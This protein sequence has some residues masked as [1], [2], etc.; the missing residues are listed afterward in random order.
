VDG[1]ASAEL[2]TEAD[3][4]AEI[5]ESAAAVAEGSF[6]PDDLVE[7]L[8]G[9]KR[10]L[11]RDGDVYQFLI[12]LDE[13]AIYVGDQPRRYE[14]VVSTIEALIEG[15]NP[16]ILGTG[17]WAMRD[18][19]QRF[20]GEIDDEA[21]YA[22]EVK[23]EGADTETIVRKRWLQKSD[24][25]T[26]Y[27][28]TELLEEAPEI[29][30]TRTDDAPSVGLE[31]PAEAYPF[32][33]QDLRL[34]RA[35]MQGL[36][37]GDRETDRE[38][39]QGRALLV[40]VRSLFADYGWADREPGVV[41]SWDVLYDVIKTDTVLIP[42]W[43][44]DLIERVGNSIDD[45]L[46]TRT[47]KAL[48][49][50][51]QVDTVPRTPANLA[52]LLADHVDVDLDQLTADVTDQLEA[53]ASKNLIREDVDES[54]TTYT[55]LS[56]ED[57]RFWQEV[58]EE[59]SDIPPHQLRENI[60]QFLENADQSRLTG[61][62]ATS[63]GTF[64]E[65][66]DV[67]YSIRYSVDRSIPESVTG[68]HDTIVIRLL[69][70]DREI[71]REERNQWQE[72]NGGPNGAEDVLVSV[73]LTEAVRRQVR[74]LI[75]MR[76]V[77]SGMADPRPEYRIR[78]GTLEEEIEDTVKD[79][80]NDG[81]VYVP[82]RETAY[83]S[84]LESFDEAV[85]EAVAEKFPNR[86]TIERPIQL[87][88]LDSLIDFFDGNGEWPLTNADADLL[89]VNTVPRTITDGWV[90][91]F[92][93]TFE[94]ED[95]VSGEQILET[96]EGRRG[97]FLGTPPEALHSLLFVLVADNRIEVRTDGER[98]TDP[99]D[100]ARIITR[101]TRFGDAVVGFD[102]DPPAEDLDDVYEAL[103]GETPG[104]DDTSILLEEITTWA[105]TNGSDIRTIVSRTTLEFESHISLT[106][107]EDALDPAFSGNTPDADLLTNPT[108]VDQATLYRDIAPLFTVAD[109]EDEGDED[110]EDEPIW[111]R[112]KTAYQ[113]LKDLHS[114]EPVVKQMQ[115][116]AMGSQ[117][118]E[119]ST[120][121]D[122]IDRA[123]ECRIEHLQT[124]YQQLTDGTTDTSDLETLREEITDAL[125]S[126]SLTADVE[127]VEA[128]YEYVTFGQ[129]RSMIE[130]AEDASEPLEESTLAVDEVVT[131][132]ETLA[133]GRD[134]LETTEDGTS[135]F[136]RLRELDA[137]LSTS[138]DGFI[139]TQINH[140]V[141]G[142][143]LPTVDRA[144]QLISQ[145]EKLQRG[146]EPE[147]EGEND[148]EQLWSGIAEHE[149]G[150][151][152]VIDPEGH[153]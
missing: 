149:S 103:L 20:I 67:S 81:R 99:D 147:D 129:L 139:A 23:L 133:R 94:D 68:K 26:E 132:I 89:G 16:P 131:E 71:V 10:Q 92:L 57:I 69:A 59:A 97:A 79:R 90:S 115:V 82:T 119:V 61:H 130:Q 75:G 9:T 2:G 47:A 50:L 153:R 43:A 65:I 123:I 1:A 44:N 111:D 73:E 66:A 58:Q 51:S 77:L 80:L 45:P 11:E 127:S 19:Q 52:R 39:I 104:T 7:R 17:Q 14:E 117:V 87:D 118:P 114:T 126:D 30:P 145:G 107:L 120:L 105:Q 40:R 76:K 137:S 122:L 146:E 100:I 21:W 54:P 29:E 6:D 56:E 72:Q 141:S 41:V 62:D 85:A 55:I 148:L 34:L 12:G 110:D 143:D 18:M 91:E 112:F 48:F 35:S 101:R 70:D 46:A 144:R 3:V 8:H 109:E 42:S 36:I 93:A 136:E 38:Y 150:T 60:Q 128:E 106:G 31:N 121:E 125:T 113:A 95:R 88:D 63:T 32:R 74:Q 96:I 64:D 84:Y 33:D 4:R 37:K 86:K 53:M 116:Y 78:Q 83:G 142:E 135:V 134:L 152:V 151:I 28:E 22:Q 102:P 25:G 27:I 13:I 108:I 98:V 24:E 49:L 138:D 140:A 124:L 15:L 5:E